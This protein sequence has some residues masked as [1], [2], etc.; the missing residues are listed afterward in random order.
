MSLYYRETSL[1][2]LEGEGIN[3]DL[4]FVVPVVKGVFAAIHGI[5]ATPG[6]YHVQFLENFFGDPDLTHLCRN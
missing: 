3:N 2:G 1:L 4:R 5:T 6:F